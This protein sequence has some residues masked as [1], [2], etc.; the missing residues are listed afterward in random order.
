MLKVPYKSIFKDHRYLYNWE[1]LHLYVTD[2]EDYD[3]E[4]EVNNSQSRCSII[5]RIKVK[6]PPIPPPMN[7]NSK[8]TRVKHDTLSYLS[9]K[10]LIHRI[11]CKFYLIFSEIAEL[12][13]HLIFLVF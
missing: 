3:F 5:Q 7:T 13:M 9:Q 10:E 4:Q 2:D 11:S 8:S 12:F 6:N 1:K